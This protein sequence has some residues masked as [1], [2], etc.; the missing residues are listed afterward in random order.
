[1]PTR[2]CR[3][4]LPEGC[5]RAA[6]LRLLYEG[7]AVPNSGCSVDDSVHR[8]QGVNGV[9][10]ENIYLFFAG[11]TLSVQG[12]QAGLSLEELGLYSGATLYMIS[13]EYAEWCRDQ[14]YVRS[15]GAAFQE[16]AYSASQ[17][18]VVD[19]TQPFEMCCSYMDLSELGA[20]WP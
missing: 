11:M 19:A 3:I 13:R 16:L 5:Y 8:A 18:A 15:V 12:G 1:M 10:P 2:A 4:T 6:S 17:A 7:S 20:G 14:A 9:H